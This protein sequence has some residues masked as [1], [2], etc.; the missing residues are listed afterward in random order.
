MYYL[1][2]FCS[3][4]IY[5]SLICTIYTVKWLSLVFFHPTVYKIGQCELM[6]E[7]SRCYGNQTPSLLHICFR[8]ILTLSAFH[9]GR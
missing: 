4:I 9:I 5:I 2:R 3:A 6:E 8:T 7:I 1:A